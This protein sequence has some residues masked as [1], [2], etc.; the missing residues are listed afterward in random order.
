[1]LLAALAAVLLA[2]FYA[3][4][5]LYYTH[6]TCALLLVTVATCALLHVSVGELSEPGGSGDVS[7]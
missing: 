5:W 2:P 7:C 3:G 1:M 4:M 6:A